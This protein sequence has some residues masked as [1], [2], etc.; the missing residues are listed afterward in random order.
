MFADELARSGRLGKVHT[1]Y[2]HIIP[3]EMRTDWLPA[4]P[5]PDRETLD[6]DLWLGPAP[7]R[8]YNAGY[9]GGCGAWLNY[10]DFGTGVAGWG[11]H[12][13]CQCQSGLGALQTS[14]VEYEYRPARDGHQVAP[15]RV[16]ALL[17]MEVEGQET[18]PTSRPTRTPRANSPDVP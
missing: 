10:Y 3:F 6:W 18:R 12:T 4:Q 13:I 8:P 9:L 17:A 14:A 7:W 16:Q 2:A 11:S 5:E 15:T 1:V